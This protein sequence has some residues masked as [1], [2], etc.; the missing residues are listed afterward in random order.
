MH[1]E[2]K[3][4]QSEAKM[5]GVE[6]APNNG[7]AVKQPAAANAKLSN[8][9]SNIEEDWKDLKRQNLDLNNEI[10]THDSN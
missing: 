3:S 1:E 4:A 2:A 8:S 6:S 9:I 10:R 5:K 7:S